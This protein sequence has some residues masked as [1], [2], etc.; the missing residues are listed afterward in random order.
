MKRLWRHF[1]FA[2]VLTL[3]SPF[4]FAQSV[5]RFPSGAAPG[6]FRYAYPVQVLQLALDATADEGKSQVV[7]IPLTMT[8]ARITAELA[9]G[10]TLDVMTSGSSREMERLLLAVPVGIRKGILGIR[11]F[12][13]DESNQS[14]FSAIQTL[15]QLKNLRAGQGDDWVDT[16]ILLQ[17]GFQV[18]KGTSY[19]GLF[20][21]LMSNRF[22]YFPR[23]V[24]EPPNEL[25]L[26]KK[27]FPRLTVEKT[28]ALYYPDPDYFW[29]NKANTVL[30][31]RLLRG[32][33]K[34]I[35]NGSLDRLFAAEYGPALRAAHLDQR[36]IFRVPNPGLGPIP[37]EGDPRYWY[38]EQVASH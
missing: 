16:S 7:Q 9:A 32:M 34:I 4:A 18:V 17:D 13:I 26:F 23:A 15:D 11:I 14:Q 22:D 37:H 30:A 38:I 20:G 2:L 31:A 33:N 12:F 27:R 5:V 29:V 1:V 36:K 35:Q 3:S 6:D 21:M 24:Y 25:L 8:T 28:L 10:K 19:A